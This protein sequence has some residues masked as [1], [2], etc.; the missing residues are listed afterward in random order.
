MRHLFLPLLVLTLI[1]AACAPAASPTATPIPPTEA[2]PTEEPTAVEAVATV[3][4]STEVP[5]TEVPA[6]DVP[7]TAVPP[8][9]VPPTEVPPTEVAQASASLP[10]WA[11]LPL[12]DVNT[13][14]TFA[15]A[16][17]SGK[18]IYV[19][20]MATWCTNCQASQQRLSSQV[21]PQTNP[22]E[23]VFVSLD[24]QTQL[25]GSTLAGY[26]QRNGFGWQFAV[27]SQDF[28]NAIVDE[29]GRSAANPPS[30][31]HFVIY[32]DGSTTGLLTGSATAEEELSLIS[33]QHGTGG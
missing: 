3:E 33:E 30:R 22:D 25:A 29:F 26:T 9:T 27:A 5:P 11:S 7:P 14:Q 15:L 28:M 20:M 18:T 21:V 23:V 19:H 12:V 24:V 17:Y 1:V 32:P 16:D 31:P 8:T 10:A 4:E 13:G 2:P 6:T